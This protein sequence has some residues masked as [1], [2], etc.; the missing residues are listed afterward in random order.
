MELEYIFPLDRPISNVP[1]GKWPKPHPLFAGGGFL[2]FAELITRFCQGPHGSRH[3]GTLTTTG[4]G[5]ET[6]SATLSVSRTRAVACARRTWSHREQRFRFAEDDPAYPGPAS[7]L[8]GVRLARANWGRNPSAEHPDKFQVV[9]WGGAR[10]ALLPG[11]VCESLCGI[12]GPSD[13][14]PCNKRSGSGRVL[15]LPACSVAGCK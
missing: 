15:D 9:G 8:E 13:L 2:L 10:M 4:G 1:G 14:C 5:A 11:E 12:H 6:A 3:G 7:H